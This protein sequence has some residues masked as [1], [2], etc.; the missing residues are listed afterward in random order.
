MGGPAG[1]DTTADA[2]PVSLDALVPDAIADRDGR[3]RYA[4]DPETYWASHLGFCPRQTYLSKLGLKDLSDSAGR[5]AAGRVIQSHVTEQ[6][7]EGHPWLKTDARGVFEGESVRFVGRPSLYD[8]SEGVVYHVKARNGWYKFTPPVERHLNQLQV[9]MAALGAHRAQIL[10]VSL[11]DLGDIQT[12]PPQDDDRTFFE[13]DAERFEALVEKA[14]AIR[15]EMFVNGI[16]TSER[17]VPF[18]PCGCYFCESE[19]LD[20]PDPPADPTD[21]IE[22]VAEEASAPLVGDGGDE[23]T[24]AGGGGKPATGG[25]TAGGDGD[26]DELGASGYDT[27]HTTVGGTHVPEPLRDLRVWVLWDAETKVALAPWQEG[28]MYP[29]EWAQHTGKNPRLPYERVR[30]LTDLPVE[31]LHETW[32]FPD[33]DDLPEQVLPAVLLPHDPPDPPLAFIDLDD[34]RN[35]ETG[36]MTCEAAGILGDLG[37]YA[38][39]SR[40][41]TGVHAYVRAGLPGDRAAF[42]ATL[43]GP[44]SIEIYDHAR[45]TGG[46]WRWLEATPKNGVPHAQLAVDALV[47]EYE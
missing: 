24:M 4:R 18:D 17:E 39:V 27:C 10:Y 9:Y 31:R 1:T 22:A 32:P 33:G 38:E 25:G 8:P 20:F 21:A 43:D 5:F 37:G 41:G 2:R 15:D 42:A 40:S 45:F 23:A 6:I 28:T 19:E 3:P 36:E 7:A 30:S 11:A 35:P 12:W 44:G 34:V 47:E 14:E 29:C 13:F 26:S 46:T 16:A